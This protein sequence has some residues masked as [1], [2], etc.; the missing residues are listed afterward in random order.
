MKHGQDPVSESTNTDA[1]SPQR[2]LCSSVIGHRTVQS[3]Q[4]R[5]REAVRH[6]PWDARG[7]NRIL[8]CRPHHSSPAACIG[9]SWIVA[10]G[11]RTWPYPEY[12]LLSAANVSV[13]NVMS[14]ESHS[15]GSPSSANTV[16]RA[17]SLAAKKQAACLGCRRSKTRC[18]R[19]SEDVHCKRCVQSGIE[20]VIPEFHVGRKKGVKK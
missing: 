18:L 16:E 4:P 9:V 12:E 5:S 7:L 20:C 17:E 1:G 14:M 3:S 10:Y 13:A 15:D 8:T 11:V 19:R 2:G 6:L